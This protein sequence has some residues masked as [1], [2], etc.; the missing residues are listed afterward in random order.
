MKKQLAIASLITLAFSLKA[1]VYTEIKTGVCFRTKEKE[2]VSFKTAPLISAEVG[3]K[4]NNWRFG[5]QVSYLKQ[6]A[7]GYEVGEN[8]FNVISPSAIHKRFTT[9]SFMV[10]TYYDYQL[11]DNFSIYLGA[12]CGVVRARYSFSNNDPADFI[13]D[14]RYSM[15]KHALA[16][17]VMT[18]IAY[19]VNE[20]WTLSL[21]YRCM[22]MESIKFHHKEIED[23]DPD[24]I[25]SLK[26]PYLHSLELGLRYRF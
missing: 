17:Q 25:P 19:D 2:M 26:T 24:F 16:V 12:G 20:H 23:I 13:P 11:K 4:I 6:K 9:L 18:G 1:D 14:G 3:Y 8:A 15:K 21:G 7:N 5:F 22:R 10:N